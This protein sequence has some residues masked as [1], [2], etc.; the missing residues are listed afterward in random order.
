MGNPEIRFDWFSE[1]TCVIA[2]GRASR[3]VLY[4]ETPQAETRPC[5]FCRGNEQMTPSARIVLRLAS[6]GDFE[7]LYGETAGDSRDWQVRIFPNMFPAFSPTE[8]RE[9]GVGQAINAY[10]YHMISVDT[11]DHNEDIDSFSDMETNAYLMAL[12]IL[13]ENLER[14]HRI[15]Y[16]SIFKNQGREAGASIPHP[17]TQVIATEKIPPSI[18]REVRLFEKTRSESGEEAMSRVIEESRIGN[19]LILSDQ[20]L[21]VFTPYAPIS[22][23]EFWIAPLISRAEWEDSLSDIGKVLRLT[24]A[25]MKQFLGEVPYNFYFHLPPRDNEVF[26]WHIEFVPRSNI[27]AGYELG[28]GAYIITS[29]PE[30]TAKLYKEHIDKVS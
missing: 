6:N 23:Y 2:K 21:A 18:V 10:G 26:C 29:S 25:A 15:R 4:A 28:F 27:H 8:P 3:P 1:R 16:V 24:I 17:H 7:T 19:R 20:H 30:E 11:P 13:K 9:D 5:P 22:P 14:D 12:R